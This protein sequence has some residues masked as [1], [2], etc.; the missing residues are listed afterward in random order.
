MSDDINWDKYGIELPYGISKPAKP[1]LHKVESILSQDMLAMWAEH[2][3]LLAAKGIPLNT[4]TPVC[5][6]RVPDVFALP[7]IPAQSPADV[8]RACRVEFGV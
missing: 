5:D 8:A 7:P 4:I 6:L 1:Y 2:K 3:A